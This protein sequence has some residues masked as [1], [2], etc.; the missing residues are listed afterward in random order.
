VGWEGEVEKS[1]IEGV[2]V[3]ER[4]NEVICRDRIWKHEMRHDTIMNV[5]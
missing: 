1:V 5:R 2:M 3:V 4:G